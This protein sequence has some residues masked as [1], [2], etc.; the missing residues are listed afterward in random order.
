MPNY[1]DA[2][3]RAA[4]L[5]RDRTCRSPV[6]AWKRAA[7][8]LF[9]DSA[10]MRGKS[11]PRATFLGLCE[12]GLVAGIDRGTYTTSRENKAYGVKAAALLARDPTLERQGSKA[13][14]ERVLVDN[15]KRHNAQMD[16]V[17]ALHQRGLLSKGSS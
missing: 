3:V 5:V 17:L 14:W 10:S 13:L 8:E 9:P 1:G 16:V 7:A 2:A 12:E 4:Q 15:T 6:E 11:C